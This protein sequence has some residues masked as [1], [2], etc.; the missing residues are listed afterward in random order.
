MSTNKASKS[1]L[2]Q[3]K[4]NFGAKFYYVNLGDFDVVWGNVLV[5]ILGHVLLGWTVFKLFRGEFMWQTI[6]WGKSGNGWN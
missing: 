4:S 1:T 5:F 6:F 2:V 3:F